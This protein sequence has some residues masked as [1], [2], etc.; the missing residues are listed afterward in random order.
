MPRYYFHLS[1]G[2]RHFS[3]AKG[4]ELN[5]IRAARAHATKHVRELKVAMCH[6]IIQDLS[7][8]SLSVVDAGGKTIF[9]IA[10]DPKR[11]RP[12]D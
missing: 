6:P 8:W 3:D 1:D 12:E 11:A 5:G 4:V 9:V 2:K 10:F 7:E